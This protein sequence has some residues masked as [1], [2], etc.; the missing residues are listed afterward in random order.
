MTE[1]VRTEVT[2]VLRMVTSTKALTLGDL[3]RFIAECTDLSD[4]AIL[5]ADHRSRY[6]NSFKKLAAAEARERIDPP[7]P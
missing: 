2:Q 7:A 1:I 3:R 5:T 6:A 4:D